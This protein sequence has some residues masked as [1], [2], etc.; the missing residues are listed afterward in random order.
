MR[1]G[2]NSGDVIYSAEGYRHGYWCDIQHHPP[3]SRI[4]NAIPHF[5][6]SIRNSKETK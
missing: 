6:P 2:R 1:K 3:N 5:H 4:Q